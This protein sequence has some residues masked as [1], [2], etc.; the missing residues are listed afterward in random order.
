MPTNG[1]PPTRKSA[2][3]N[4]EIDGLNYNPGLPGDDPVRRA[5]NQRARIRR[6]DISIREALKA[7]IAKAWADKEAAAKRGK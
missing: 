2:A 4:D 7:A 1:G 5:D 6:G 3:S